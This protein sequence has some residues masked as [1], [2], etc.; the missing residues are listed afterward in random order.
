[1]QMVNVFKHKTYLWPFMIHGNFL[2]I[3]LM[4]PIFLFRP[5]RLFFNR[6]IVIW[7]MLLQLFKGYCGGH[8]DGTIRGHFLDNLA[9]TCSMHM[10]WFGVVS[11]MGEILSAG[12]RYVGNALALGPPPCQ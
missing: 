5:M 7:G 12:E 4:L 11:G 2:N 8:E 3:T 10:W 1:M 6:I 9:I